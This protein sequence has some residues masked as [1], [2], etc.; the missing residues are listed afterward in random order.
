[1]NKNEAIGISAALLLLLFCLALLL[2]PNA[3]AAGKPTPTEHHGFT[4]DPTPDPYPG[5][6]EDLPTW[7][8]WFLA[9]WEFLFGN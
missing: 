8:R 4:R 9:L 5:P 1:M 3:Q 2:S 7:P 6:E